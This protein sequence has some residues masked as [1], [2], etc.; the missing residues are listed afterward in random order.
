MRWWTISL[1]F[2]IVVGSREGAAE[3]DTTLF[4][5]SLRLGF[6]G[7]AHSGGR[8]DFTGLGFDLGLEVGVHV[9]PAL[10]LRAGFERGPRLFNDVPYESEGDRELGD[11]DVIGAAELHVDRWFVGGGGGW[12]RESSTRISTPSTAWESP[13]TTGNSHA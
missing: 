7:Q 6:G 10:T 11:F 1:A 2:A 12:V 4:D 8:T 5:A 13:A 9:T 3:P